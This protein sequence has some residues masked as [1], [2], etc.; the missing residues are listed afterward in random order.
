MIHPNLDWDSHDA[1]LIQIWMVI[2]TCPDPDWDESQIGIA[3]PIQIGMHSKL[4]CNIY[5]C[6]APIRI[7]SQSGLGKLVTTSKSGFGC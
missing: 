1:I 4:G 3:I 2:T 7:L 5:I 6:Y